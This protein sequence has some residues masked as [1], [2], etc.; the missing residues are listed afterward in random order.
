MQT[1]VLLELTLTHSITLA[2]L[3]PLLSVA[4]TVILYMGAQ[5]KGPG[6]FGRLALVL[7]RPIQLKPLQSTID[8]HSSYQDMKAHLKEQLINRYK[9]IVLLLVLFLVGN[10]LATF[11]HVLSDYAINIIDP[12]FVSS[13]WAQIIIE[14][15]FNSGWY[16]TLPWYGDRFLPPE[17][18]IVYHE[19]WSWI[20]FSAGITDDLTFF[21][22]A[23]NIV[24]IVS[25]LFGIVFLLPLA[26]KPVRM[27]FSQSLFFFITGM[28]VLTRGFF[29]CLSQA[30]QLEYGS[31]ILRYGIRLVYPGQLVVTTEAA[32][33]STLLPVIGVLCLVFMFVGDLLWK[34]HYP[35]HRK[36]RLLF[37]L[38][39][40]LTY[41]ISF[42]LIMTT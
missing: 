2:I 27:S 18:A 28:L 24:L 40:A 36:S 34:S 10:I 41:W 20:Y 39:I 29:G 31:S 9:L 7:T 33:I 26:L 25:I 14:S 6:G 21:M 17:G 5:R 11:Y 32:I 8:E 3:I 37:V 4:M 15:P 42:I 30:V 12:D 19:T 16:G 1:N 13:T 23:T 22:G 38:Y 35:S